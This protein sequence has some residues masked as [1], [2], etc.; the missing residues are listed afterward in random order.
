MASGASGEDD[1]SQK[2]GPSSSLPIRHARDALGKEAIHRR[3]DDVQLVLNAKVDKV[4]VCSQH[5]RAFP[6]GE[7]EQQGRLGFHPWP[8]TKQDVVWW[9][10]LGVVGEVQ[11]A[12]SF[13]SAEVAEVKAE[14]PGI[15]AAAV[16]S[17]RNVHMAHFLPEHGGWFL[18]LLCFRQ[19]RLVLGPAPQ[20]AQVRQVSLPPARRTRIN[21]CVSQAY[22]RGSRFE[23]VRLTAAKRLAFFTLPIPKA[24]LSAV[25]FAGRFCWLS[26]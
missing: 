26:T 17:R 24:L 1:G 14:R 12:G 2:P 13:L 18:L 3:L 25:A 16:A 8:R 22:R 11:R 21:G 6:A 7:V 10:K 5:A 23:I 20:R 9:S 19:L 15:A 4:G